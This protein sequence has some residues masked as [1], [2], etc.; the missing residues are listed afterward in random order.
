VIRTRDLVFGALAV[1]LVALYV[2]AGSRIAPALDPASSPTPTPTKPVERVE[3]PRLDGTLAFAIRGDVYVL[4]GGGYVPL[5]SEGRSYQPSISPDGRSVIFARTEEIDGKRIVDGQVVP[6]HLRFSNIVRKDA[7]GGAETIVANGLIRAA[8]GFHQVTWFDAPALSPDGKRIAVVADAG[9]GHSELSLLDAQSGSRAALL[10]QGSD[11]A[12]PAWSPDGATIAVTSYTLGAPRLLL[13]SA[14]GKSSRQVKV[15]AE[16][17][18]YRPAYS[19]DGSWLL[20]T[21]RHDGMNDLHAVPTTGGRDVALTTGGKSWNG[22]FSPDGK[23]VAFLRERDGVIDL[24]AMDL[25][26]ALSGG[27]PRPAVKLT[28]GEGVDGASRPAWGR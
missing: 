4:S 24:Y 7:R 28:R 10:S 22:V 2:A 25:A 20:Y 6:A 19:P 11:L 1:A 23:Q 12:D 3:A 21:L 17:D 8:S 15:G 27:S 14:D 13:V 9:D 26:D 16:G 18:A 5:T